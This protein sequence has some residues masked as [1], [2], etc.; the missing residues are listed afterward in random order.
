MKFSLKYLLKFIEHVP[1]DIAK[2]SEQL[3]ELGLELESCTKEA[4]DYIL[5]V[6]TAPNRADLLGLIGIAREL[7]A[8]NNAKLKYSELKDDITDLILDH[9]DKKHVADIDVTVTDPKACPKYL[10]RIIRNV[11][12]EKTTPEWMQQVLHHAGISLISPIVDI[13]NYV[14]LELGQP[15]HAFDLSKIT[16]EIV[17]RK[18]KI[19]EEITLLNNEKI[20]LSN[21]D[22]IIAD[23]KQPLA[24][25]GIMGGLNSAITTGTT[26]IVLECAYFEPIGIRMTTRQ[27]NLSSDSAQRFTRNIDPALQHIAML[28]FTELLNEIVGGDFFPIISVVNEQFLPK[29]TVIVLSRTKIKTVLGTCFSDQKIISILQNLKMSLL[30]KLNIGWEVTIPSW[31]QD[32]TIQEDLIEEIARFVG[33]SNITGQKLSLPLNFKFPDRALTF[34]NE[35]QYKHCLVSRGYF[36]AITYSFIDPE[37]AN[38]F[39]HGQDFYR[40]KNPMS[41]NMSIM[42][43]GLWPG[44]V[45]ALLHNQNRQQTRVRLFELGTVF[46]FN[47]KTGVVEQKKK[48]AGIASGNLL[49]ENWQ[50]LQQKVD[51]FAIKSDVEA[52]LRYYSHRITVTFKATNKLV[53]LHTSQAAEIYINNTMVGTVG[54]LHP[55]LIK[56]L[57]IIEPVFLFELDLTLLAE[58][59]ELAYLELPKFVELSKFPA[60]RRDF[61]IMVD[62]AITCDYIQKTIQTSCGELLKKIIFF[63]LYSRDKLSD[64]KKSMAFG[65]ILQHPTRTLE[66]TDILNIETNIVNSLEKIGATLR[67]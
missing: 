22:L 9:Y 7:A 29:T 30:K 2:I 62:N 43:P 48:L 27:H 26:D 13:T 47:A 50:H 39:Y 42:R 37:F 5:E 45:T 55:T 31:R 64:N 1:Y 61:S 23:S 15:L 20:T 67:G 57:S 38:L 24:V 44:L 16:G 36:E 54:A 51:L 40:L 52:I 17:V 18:A 32:I 65:V 4:D 28:R 21:Q 34:T 49:V 60:I 6:A 53:A 46:L 19:N 10:I 11:K 8:L 41:Q 56:N 66:A 58:L 3:T 25:A 63:D 14:M 35:L 33:Y 12:T 59:A